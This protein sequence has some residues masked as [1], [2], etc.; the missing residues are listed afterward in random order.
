[1]GFR[2]QENRDNPEHTYDIQVFKPCY[3][4]F[5]KDRVVRYQTSPDPFYED[6][7]A[8]DPRE[9]RAF[10]FPALMPREI[11]FR[12]QHERIFRR[13]RV[14]DGTVAEIGSERRMSM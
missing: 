12:T 7:L 10:P 1:M 13:L 9:V 6:L 4:F 5:D 3:A 11:L 8:D 14:H 2:W